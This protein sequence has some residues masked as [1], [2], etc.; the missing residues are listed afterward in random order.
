VDCRTEARD[1]LQSRRARISPEAT[2]LGPLGS[3]RRVPGLRREEVARL[4]GVSVDY[5]ARLEKGHLETASQSV[6]AGIATALRLDRAERSHLYALA[7]AARGE[8][9]SKP[10]S[11]HDISAHPSLQWMLDAMTSCPAYIR[12]GRLDVLASNAMGRSLYEPLFDGAVATPNLAAFCFLD[13]RAVELFPDWREVAEGTV[14]LL[15]AQVGREPFDTALDGLIGCLTDDSEEF[16]RLWTAHEVREVVA[17][18]K[19]INHAVVGM[20]SLAVQPLEPAVGTG[21]TLVAYAAEPGSE[22]ADRL[23]RLAGRLVGA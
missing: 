9:S 2:G 17:E 8:T 5:Y 4:A 3:R 13:P 14:A 20:L 19:R 10:Q 22:S 23:L 1:F 15:R 18:T 16:R 11:S 6:L 12:N 7:R 21:L